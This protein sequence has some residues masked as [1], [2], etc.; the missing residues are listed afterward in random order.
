VLRRT[1]R[2]CILCDREKF[3][4]RKQAKRQAQPA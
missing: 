1:N 2:H 3:H 4:E